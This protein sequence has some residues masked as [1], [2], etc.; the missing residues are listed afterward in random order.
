MRL[1]RCLGHIAQING[2]GGKYLRDLACGLESWI[3]APCSVDRPL[4][5][6][7]L[8]A[9]QSPDSGF[10]LSLQAL[11]SA[12]QS[13]PHKPS[14]HTLESKCY[15]LHASAYSLHTFLESTFDNNATNVL[16]L[17][18]PRLAPASR[19]DDRKITTRSK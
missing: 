17:S 7:S 13:A 15:K 14:P 6:S 4:V 5:L 8:Q 19:G 10:F 12:K 18:S 2:G 11:F 9:L 1:W 3:S 16:F